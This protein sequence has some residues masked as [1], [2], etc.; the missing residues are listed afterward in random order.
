MDK[1]SGDVDKGSGFGWVHAEFG[2]GRGIEFDGAGEFVDESGGGFEDS[3][4]RLLEEFGGGDGLDRGPVALEKVRPTGEGA[5]DRV[6]DIGSGGE[7]NI[8]EYAL[9]GGRGGVCVD[10]DEVTVRFGLGRGSSGDNG[11]SGGALKGLGQERGEQEG[12]GDGITEEVD[13]VL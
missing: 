9:D 11:V 12:D 4:L 13:A 6:D 2:E 8:S 3:A 7:A 10:E 1:H 5:I